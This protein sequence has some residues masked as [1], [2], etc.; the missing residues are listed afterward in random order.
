MKYLVKLLVLSKSVLYDEYIE[1]EA[2]NLRGAK[3]LA[4]QKYNA[5]KSK[6]SSVEKSLVT[7]SLVDTCGELLLSASNPHKKTEGMCIK[8][9]DFLVEDV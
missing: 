9:V 2:F 5:F 8:W 1:I 3:N 7:I 6:L 4:T